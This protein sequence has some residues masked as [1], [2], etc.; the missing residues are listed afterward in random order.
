ML[1][2]RVADALAV[3]DDLGLEHV[4]VSGEG[5]GAMT[6]IKL[7]ADHPERVD[8]LM[9]INGM[10]RGC[11]GPGYDLGPPPEVI[12]RQAERLRSL[13][14]TGG[15]T[16]AVAPSL[17][18]DP[19]FAARFEGSGARPRCRGRLGAQPDGRRCRGSARSSAGSHAGGLQRR[20][21]HRNSGAI[22]PPCC[23]FPAPDCSSAPRQASTG[24]AAS[25]KR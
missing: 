4:A 18:H 9:L 2:E 24:E 22:S 1:D 12:E 13:W 8:K 17:A 7:A 14:G 10:A 21:A 3:L 15:V 19:E 16:A 23:P 11:A 20:H 6:A 5:D 25:L